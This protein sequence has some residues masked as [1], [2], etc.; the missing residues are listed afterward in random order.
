[1]QMLLE[2]VLLFDVSVVGRQV[3]HSGHAGWVSS[4][5]LWVAN[6]AVGGREPRG[7]GIAVH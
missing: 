1:M 7:G 3:V 6:N 2:V 5:F 4:G